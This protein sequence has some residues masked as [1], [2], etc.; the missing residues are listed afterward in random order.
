MSSSSSFNS[1]LPRDAGPPPSD[2]RQR[3][4]AEIRERL[5][6][7]ALEQFAK[8]G[9]TDTTVEDITN[10][11]DVGKG[12]FFNHFPSKDHILVAFSDLQI[13]KLEECVR[14]GRQSRVPMREFLSGLS[15]KMIAEPGRSPEVTRALLQANL[16]SASVREAVRENYLRGHALLSELMELGQER[17]EIR[18]D[19][20]AGDLS[21]IFRQVVMGTV[22]I[23]SVFGDSSLPDRIKAALNVLW[24]GVEPRQLVTAAPQQA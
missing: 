14:Q 3:R 10:A 1:S 16:S 5:F 22:L 23:W 18:R 12:T 6:R 4:S 20:P 24:T 11:A 8:K 2:R 21:H 19:I 7:A 9:F 17:G 13:A 15:V